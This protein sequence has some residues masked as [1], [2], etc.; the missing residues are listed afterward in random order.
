MKNRSLSFISVLCLL[1]SSL[2]I[3]DKAFATHSAGGEIIYVHISDSTYQ[4]FMKFYR[5][6]TGSFEP[7]SFTLCCHN[8]CTN[9]SFSVNMP[10]WTG[11]L[12]PDGRPNG[13]PVSAGCSNSFNKCDNTQYFLPGYREWWYSCIITLPLKCNY[14]EF[15]VSLC[16]R[17]T[18]SNLV[19]Q[20]NFYVET[21]F[22]SS[23]TWDNSSPFYSVKPIPYVCLN[24]QYTY[25]NGALDA[26]GDSLWSQM[27]NPLNN[28]SCAATNTNVQTVQNATPPITFPNN[29]M[30]T[31]N[32]FVLT[33][34][35]GQMTFTATQS[36]AAALSIKTSEYRKNGNVMTEIGSIMRDVQV[37]VIP[38][39]IVPPT[40]D[41]VSVIGG[42]FGNGLVYGCVGQK[43][44]F[45]FTVYSSDTETVLL[46]EDNLN[47]A[48]P[49]AT[50]NYSNQGT[51]TVTGC[52][53]WTPTIND[54]GSHNFLVLIKDSTCKPP[55]I[56]LQYAKVIDLKIWGPV[57]ATPDTSICYGEP[58]FLGVVGGG[59][60]SWKV[61]NGTDPSLNSTNIPNPIATPKVT[62]TYEVTSTVNTYCPDLNKDTVTITVLKGPDMTGVNDDTTCPGVTLPLDLGIVK[63]PGVTYNVKWTP[64]TGLSSATSDKPDAKLKTTT[65]Y[66]VEVGSSDN[67]CK[68][69]DTVLIDVLTG[70]TLDNHD[71]QICVGQS[72][73]V[74]GKVDARYNIVWNSKTDGAATYNPS[75]DIVTTIT[76][77][78]TGKHTYVIKGDY[79]KCKNVPLGAPNGDTTADF[80][81]DVQPIPTASIDD[82]ASMCYGDTMQLSAIVSP[83]KYSKYTY[84]WTPGVALDFPDRKNPIFSAITEG[85]TTLRFIVKTPAGCSDTD[86]VNL[87]VYAASF[88]FLPGDT[89]ICA[90]DSI[91]IDMDVASGTKFYWTP[92][93]NISSI[94][95]LQPRVW[96]VADQR[97]SVFGQDSVG[98][99]DTA[100]I[101]ITVR[102]RAIIEIPDKVTIYPGESYT[103][104]PGGNCL[105]YTWFPPLGLN[106]ADVSN[107]SVSPEVDTRY[108]VHGRTEA[109]CAVTDSIDIIVINDSYLDLPNAFTPGR[110][111][112][113]TLKI[114]RRGIAELKEFAVYNRWGVK[115][116]E[117]SDINEGWDGTYNGASQPTGVYIYTIKA[118]TPSGH[119]IQKQGNITLLR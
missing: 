1:L 95:S 84:S 87:N 68:T 91:S 33:G 75:N 105:Y 35:N 37:Q 61:L 73:D 71:T 118:V 92:D 16:C 74:L 34:G 103:M 43:L 60:Y 69:I 2:L 29:P 6:C 85:G 52:F 14:W 98:C 51:D 104:D 23:F 114:V 100:H 25:N 50:I 111:T 62:T 12:P 113:G 112:N 66:T 80:V 102:P 81:I 42:D 78:D 20:D 117:T 63:K 108:I 83:E 115:V 76:P 93:L 101:N 5:D 11:T 7:N 64:A 86:E 56:L 8:T 17:N 9:Q 119:A 45:C 79:Y 96:P 10:K 19:G 44:D 4:F 21:I 107:P 28:T 89:A 49:G 31:N 26:D 36:G 47:L 39:T 116:F 22:N 70:L 110:R 27:I 59:N 106:N 18:S 94:S 13:A 65:Q 97:Y 55:G 88:L 72:V 41:T 90:G 32:S 58:A 109:G 54:V 38:C 67:R 48:I 15:G 24:R 30:Q 77:G 99:L 57:E 3:P 40:L 82:D 46:A 53:N